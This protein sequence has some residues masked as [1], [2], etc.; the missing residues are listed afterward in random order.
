MTPTGL[1]YESGLST[2]SKFVNNG[3]MNLTANTTTIKAIEMTKSARKN[4][5]GWLLNVDP[6]ADGM[7]LDQFIALRIAR[8]SR[9]KAAKL[10]AYDIDDPNHLL[11]KKSAVRSGQ[12]LW[13][14]RPMPDEDSQPLAPK[15]LHKDNHLLVI[16]KPSGLATHPSSSRFKTT[17]TYWLNQEQN[18]SEFHPVHRLDVETSGVLLCAHRSR[19]SELAQ[20]FA[21]QRVTKKYMAVLSGLCASDTWSVETPLGL[22]PDHPSGVMMTRGPLA[23]HTRFVVEARGLRRTLVSVFPKTGRQHQIRVHAKISGYPILGDKLYGPRPD[24]FIESK[25]RDLTDIEECELGW[26]RH[27]LHAHSLSLDFDGQARTFS[28]KIPYEFYTLLGDSQ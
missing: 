28:A 7:R 20:T 2:N 23:A 14:S 21:D 5:P 8:L 18:L 15:I 3:A 10:S 25:R 12:R 6:S 22:C 13:V 1:S 4:E 17:V 19:L 16:D 24:L 9:T 27:A 26:C 11:R